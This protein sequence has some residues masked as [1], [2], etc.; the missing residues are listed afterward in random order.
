MNRNF[1]DAMS[2]ATRLTQAGDLQAAMA[3]IQS[4]LGT[5]RAPTAT[6]ASTST[7]GPRDVIDIEA[8][9]V[10]AGTAAPL[11]DEEF[12]KGFKNSSASTAR[13]AQQPDKT[14]AADAGF[15]HAREGQFARARRGIFARPTLEDFEPLVPPLGG[16]FDPFAMPTQRQTR[17]WKPAPHQGRFINGSH[18][19]AGSTRSYKLYVPPESHGKK[20]PLVVMLHGCTQDPDDFAFGTGMNEAA[21]KEGCYVLY[22]AQSQKMNPQRCWNWFKHSHQVRGRGEAALLAGMTRAVIDEHGVDAQRVY[23]A[24]LSAGG[25]MAAILGAAYPDVFAA[26]GVHSGLPVG[27][28]K[29]LPSAL[30]A[31]QRGGDGAVPLAPPTIVFHGDQDSIVHPLN[32]EQAVVACAHTKIA[33]AEV[34]QG[35]S[36]GGHRYTRRIWR[37][38]GGKPVAEHWNVHGAGHAWSG[39]SC[40]GSYTDSRGPDATEAMLRFFLTHRLNAKAEATIADEVAS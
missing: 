9:V 22:P 35:Q 8:R 17:A 33:R 28:A 32:G 38:T 18:T 11:Q 24:G 26:V 19:D 29:D 21:C 5:G 30:A 31:M 3:L 34:E 15:A 4:A 23:V 40:E 13:P 25:A 12:P 16:R 36:R 37:N 14:A 20:L 39:G 6:P 27:A 10:E 1:Q 7:P 2:E